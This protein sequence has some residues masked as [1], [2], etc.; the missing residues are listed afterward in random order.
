MVI[1]LTDSDSGTVY[2]VN[3]SHIVSFSKKTLFLADSQYIA[4]TPEDYARLQRVF[5]VVKE[6]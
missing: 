2:F 1:R 3:M 6:D 5:D 4:L